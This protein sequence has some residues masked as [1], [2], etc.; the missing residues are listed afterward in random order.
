MAEAGEC[1]IELANG[2]RLVCP[3]EPEEC[4][5]VRV[6]E[7]D[8][9]EIAYWVCDEWAEAPTEVMGAI[10]GAA[11]GGSLPAAIIESPPSPT[12]IDT[13]RGALGRPR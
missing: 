4:S 1:V 6:E 7:A 11:G 5:F 10:L 9:T 3:A 8:G 12:R 13:L 2:R